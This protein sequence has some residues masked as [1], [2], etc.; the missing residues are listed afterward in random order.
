MTELRT[1]RGKEI[2][3]EDDARRYDFRMGGAWAMADG[4]RNVPYFIVPSSYENPLSLVF[5]DDGSVKVTPGIVSCYGRFAKVSEETTVIDDITLEYAGPFPKVC[6]YI[7]LRFDLDD[8]FNGGCRFVT[9]YTKT[10]DRKKTMFPDGG[11]K[12]NLTRL[13]YGIYDVPI[14][15]FIY[16]SRATEKNMRFTGLQYYILPAEPGACL[17]A[18]TIPD[19]G[20][21]GGTKASTLEGALSDGSSLV[22]KHA[23]ISSYSKTFGTK[24]NGTAIDGNTS[25]ITM[26]LIPLADLISGEW[27][28][29]R[30]A[31]PTIM[32]EGTI[33]VRLFVSG[34]SGSSYGEKDIT[35]GDLFGTGGQTGGIFSR[36]HTFA[37]TQGEIESKSIRIYGAIDFKHT[38][39]DIVQGTGWKKDSNPDAVDPWKYPPDGG[40][41]YKLNVNLW[42]LIVGSASVRIMKEKSYYPVNYPG[43]AHYRDY[44]LMAKNVKS[45][46]LCRQYIRNKHG[47]T[48][49]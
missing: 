32:L 2:T 48:V 18:D 22:P 47:G 36:G 3:A 25:V 33:A 46:Y 14:A 34:Y 17:S 35:T 20:K 16:D 27:D 23:H 42:T 45:G 30:I 41:A 7:Y 12:D 29:K 19:D 49:E 44:P 6:V 26:K 31:L 10:A 39:G 4:S 24:G 38:I 37:L 15:S 8:M 9:E 13:G 40:Q 28:S 11:Y 5:G 21:V 43:S 1:R